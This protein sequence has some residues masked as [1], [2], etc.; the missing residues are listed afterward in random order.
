[1]EE[2]DK[3][4]EDNDD[5]SLLDDLDLPKCFTLKEGTNVY[6]NILSSLIAR[7]SVYFISEKFAHS[8]PNTTLLV[9]FSGILGIS[10]DGSTYLRPSNYTSKILALIYCMRLLVLERALPRRSYTTIR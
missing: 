8:R 10:V 3:I 4:E 9:Y 6:E 2:D 5:S 1:M 7:L